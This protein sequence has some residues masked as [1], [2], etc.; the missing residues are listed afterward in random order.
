MT[1]FVALNSTNPVHDDINSYGMR[2]VV[3]AAKPVSADELRRFAAGLMTAIASACITAGAKDVSHV[4]AFIE[5]ETGFIHADTVG[6]PD[7]VKVEG[8]DGKP[9]ESFRLVVNSVIYG[10][11]AHAV[12]EITESETSKTVGLFGLVRTCAEK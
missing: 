4:K 6:N 5:H 9:A 7:N 10:L 8:R 3:T 2:C 11:S 1:G 12:K